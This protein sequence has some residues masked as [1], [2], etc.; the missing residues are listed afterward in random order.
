M[1]KEGVDTLFFFAAANFPPTQHV[2][3]AKTTH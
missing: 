1:F 2:M 3:L